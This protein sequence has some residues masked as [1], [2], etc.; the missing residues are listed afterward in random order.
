MAT[1]YG[2]LV[3]YDTEKK[4]YTPDMLE[5]FTAN[6]DSTEW[7]L[8]IRPTSSSPTAPTSMPKPCGS[9]LNRHRSG[10]ANPAATNCAEYWACPRNSQSSNVY[11]AL[12]KDIVATTR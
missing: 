12:V 8:K 1:I 2:A 7:T 4:T 11:M 5:S 10:N 6:A 9:P 3:R